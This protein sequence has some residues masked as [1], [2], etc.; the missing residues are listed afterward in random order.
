MTSEEAAALNVCFLQ[1][2]TTAISGATRDG[3]ATG[4]AVYTPLGAEEAYHGILPTDFFL[5][6]Q[7]GE[8]FGERLLFATKDLFHLGFES[9]CLINSDSPTVSARGFL[10]QSGSLDPGRSCRSLRRGGTLIGLKKCI[11]DFE[12]IDWRTKKF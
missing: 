9:V 10:T 7:R 1:D 3:K 11:A 12:R 6:L 4:V 5:V 8:S 2:I